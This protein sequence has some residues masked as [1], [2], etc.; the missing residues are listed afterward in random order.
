MFFRASLFSLALLTAAQTALAQQ[1]IPIAKINRSTPVSF[2]KEVLPILQR[3]CLACHNASKKNGGLVLESP[4][5]MISGGDSGASI[6]P[7]DGDSS[8][9]LMVASHAEDPIMPPAGNKVA[10]KP[11]TSQELGLLKLWIDQGAKSGGLSTLISP[12]RW[13][14][15]PAGNHPIYT[16]A[17]SPDGQFAACGRANQIFIYHV[18]TG[19][20]VTRLTD[21]ALQE[22]SAEKLAGV[23]HL[24]IVQSLVFSRQGD[25]LA[26]GGFRNVK[27]W[28]YPRDVQQATLPGAAAV[29]AVAVSP[30][31]SRIALGYAD[32]SIKLWP[33]PQPEAE[34]PTAP[35]SLA[36]HTAKVN[37]LCFSSDG[38]H[39]VSASEDKTVR[40]WNTSDGQ[41]T[42]R[43]DAPT[44]LSAVT[45]LAFPAPAAPVEAPSAAPTPAE[46][47]P[48]AETGSSDAEAAVEAPIPTVDHVA[49]GGADNLI[50]LW[51]L[52]TELPRPLAEAPAESNV[53]AVSRDGELLAMANA[54]G[55]VRVVAAETN[56]LVHQWQAV[57]PIHAMALHVKA[58]E[59]ETAPETAPE[60]A[61]EAAAESESEADA[62]ASPSIRLAT[63]GE[64]GVVRVW[65]VADGQLLLA[66]RGS[67]ASLE[68]VDFR[69]DGNQLAAAAADG[70][71][72]L[73]SLESLESTSLGSADSAAGVAATSADGKLLA[74]NGTVGGRP[75]ILVRDIATGQLLHQ[76]LGHEK[77]IVDI[78]F[79]A[80]GARIVS[81]SEDA[82]ARVWDLK[83]ARF[84]EIARFNGHTAAVTAVAFNSNATQILSGS[85]DK[86]LKLWNVADAAEVM[87]FAGHT[88]GIV[89]VA[90]PPNNQPISASADK[91]VRTWNAANGQATRTVTASTTPTAFRLSRDGARYAVALSDNTIKVCQA[92]DGK[93]LLTL[94]GHQDA[95][96]TLAFNVDSTRLVSAATSRE[97]I[98]WDLADGRLLEIVPGEQL[99]CVAYGADPQRI[100]TC[101]D[102]GGVWLSPLRFAG[103]LRGMTQPVTSIVYHPTTPSLYTAC[104]DGTVRGFNVE[105]QQQL[106]SANHAAPV[107]DLALRGDGQM[108]ASAGENNTI[109]LWSSTNGAASQPA[110]LTGFTAPVRSVEFTPDG[111]RVV[112]A[113]GTADSGEVLVFNLSPPAGLLEQA[114]V[115]H[116][117]QVEA[118]KAIGSQSRFASISADGALLTWNALAVRHIPGHTQPV[119]SL[120]AIPPAEGTTLPDLLSGSLDGTARRWNVETG[121]QLAQ[122]SHGGA[123]TSVAVRGDGQRF[124]T[125]SNNNT[126]KLWNAANNQQLAQMQGDLRA[127]T[128]VAKLTQSRSDVATQVA[129]AKTAV[130]AAERELPLKIDAEKK[131]AAAL[132]A[133][134]KD[135]QAKAAALSTA[136]TAKAAAEQDAIQAAATAQ[137]AAV[138]M[139]Q[140][141]QR[142]LAMAAEAR[143]LA[144]KAEQARAI[145]AA[146]AENAQLAKAHAEAMAAAAKAEADAKAAEAAK[147]TPAK[148]AATTAQ[149]AAASAQKALTAAKPFNDAATALTAAQAVLRTAQQT[150]ELA[151]REQKS[152]ADTVPAAKETLAKAEAA[153]AKIESALAAA[154]EA[155]Q[156][157]QMP[158]H[159]VAF[160]PDGRT[161]ASGGDF[162][163]VHTWDADTGK[164]ISSSVGHAGS[165][166]CLAYLGSD[167]LIS[168]SA[169]NSAVVWNLNPDWR[170]ERVIGD[171]NDPATLVDRVTA[172][173]FSPNGDLLITG[174]GVPSRGGELK[175]W[176][177]ADGALARD[178][179]DPHTD[180]IAA[181]A[182]SPD[183]RSVAT[184]A[185]DKYVKSWDLATGEQRIQFEGHTNYVT[186]V[187]WRAGSKMLVTSGSDATIRTWNAATGDRI[188]VI[189]GFNKQVS[190]VKFLGATQYTVCASGDPLVRMHNADNGGVQRTFGGVAEYMFAVDAVGDLTNGVVAAGGHD[191]VLRLW[192]TA[193]VVLHEIGPPEPEP[194]PTTT[195]E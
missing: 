159:A 81:G 51:R 189:V 88:A 135:V 187:A 71:V 59:T 174:G 17:L 191:G 11:L 120:A 49:T 40:V 166:A 60:A 181:L 169:D 91:T 87:N 66:L 42:G 148:T 53:L 98:V 1:A 153:L 62:G 102:L 178:V 106:F 13:H 76:L 3:N 142:A 177:V 15:L 82:T 86:S 97:A 7:G 119:T 141:N 19:Q 186:G 47:T 171:I 168:G 72:T 35:L 188:R 33:A 75:A 44:Q 10:A 185:A 56:E 45:T 175:I 12:E 144:E 145:A 104:A 110:Q 182:V 157:A 48:S 176:N 21:P 136:S 154:V 23:A 24:D 149:T 14:P 124:A 69:P 57:G 32:N 183:G 28:R 37:S 52:P 63:V 194:T 83:D 73:W 129:D 18:P 128:Q 112:G 133:A 22:A 151:A 6:E 39:L 16:L 96:H 152:A 65:R 131:A 123:V 125:S 95:I 36:G 107:H 116:A 195:S 50:R 139:E 55:V 34:G 192:T 137:K 79:S 103:A 93:E 132:A 170:L 134:E 143:L 58:A 109:K 90:M 29:S 105:N 101:D 158:V 165:V 25:L 146:D 80:D 138:A 74:T 179:P 43:I 64:D 85:A 99:T 162:G 155:E 30:D 111:T 94:S 9:L 2:E 84:P 127:K 140:A 190:A 89:G 117:G 113:G 92:S 100:I 5:A 8:Y 163:A 193:G 31:R 26:S 167:Q 20:L 108:L 46:T 161:L 180:A 173:D 77:P 184:A 115:G 78:A 67:L 172:V 164:A 126:L 61:V 130:E 54:E 38:S 118:C 4:A 156:K 114:I 27:L 122:L 160:S 41:L 147:E 68:S 150:H 121:A 70:G